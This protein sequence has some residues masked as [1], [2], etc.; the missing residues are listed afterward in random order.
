[1]RPS[2]AAEAP[3]PSP[4]GDDLRLLEAAIDSNANALRTLLAGGAN[5]NARD[6][7]GMTALHHVASTG[8][9]VCLRLLVA[10]GR[11]DYRILDIH[12]RTAAELA[13]E[14]A[15]D[16]AVGRLLSKHEIRQARIE[17]EGR[18]RN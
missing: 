7:E 2:L 4:R 11:C 3:L 8:A 6:E 15:R 13:I 12:G 5:V 17:G 9:R 10:T 18:R 1:M 14:W 16:Y